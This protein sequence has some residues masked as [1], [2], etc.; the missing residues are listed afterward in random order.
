[1][2]KNVQT[3]NRDRVYALNTLPD[4]KYKCEIPEKTV[5]SFNELTRT[6]ELVDVNLTQQKKIFSFRS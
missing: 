5:N 3:K 1:M 4:P 6:I 2:S